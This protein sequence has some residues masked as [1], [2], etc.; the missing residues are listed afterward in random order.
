MGKMDQFDVVF[1]GMGKDLGVHIGSLTA[2]QKRWL[3]ARV[4]ENEYTP[5]ALSVQYNLPRQSLN[6]WIRMVRRGEPLKDSA[7]NRGGRKHGSKDKEKR[8]RRS[9]EEMEEAKKLEGGGSLPLKKRRKVVENEKE[10][11]E[12]EA[13]QVTTVVVEEEDRVGAVK[14]DGSLRLNAHFI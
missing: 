9:K 4:L 13:P 8:T 12:Q 11:K 2:D 1:T 7:P 6:R 14:D 10:E 3:A 5:V